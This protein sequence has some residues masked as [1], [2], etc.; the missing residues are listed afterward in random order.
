MTVQEIFDL[1]LGIFL[2]VSTVVVI[3]GFLG[4]KYGV[5]EKDNKILEQAKEIANLENALKEA[6]RKSRKKKNK[7]SKVGGTKNGK[8]TKKINK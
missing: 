7:N 3:L 2:I 6:K 4:I 8:K 5:V 1:I